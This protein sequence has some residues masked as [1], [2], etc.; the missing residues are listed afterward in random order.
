[1]AVIKKTRDDEC[2]QVCEEQETLVQFYG[3]INWY[4]YCGKQGGDFSKN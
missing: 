1:M 2:W 4:S 3:N